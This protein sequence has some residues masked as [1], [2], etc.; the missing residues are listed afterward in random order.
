ME[1]GAEHA[2]DAE[3]V[4]G[5]LTYAIG[6]MPLARVGVWLAGNQYVHVDPSPNW[7][8]GTDVTVRVT[9]PGGLW[10]EDAFRVAVSWSCPGPWVSFVMV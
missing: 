8:G 2:S 10:D 6:G 5:E 1:T 7:C 4:P 9:D 3:S